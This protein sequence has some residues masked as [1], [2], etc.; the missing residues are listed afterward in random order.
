[1]VEAMLAARPVIATR[2]GSMPEA[3]IDQQ[4]GLLIEKNDV[5]ELAAALRCLRDQPALRLQLGQQA[6]QLAQAQ[7][8]AKIM[9]TRYEALWQQVCSYPAAPRWQVPRPKD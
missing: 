5:E 1:M 9:A 6:R 7:F 3:V 4:T 2:V 8:T